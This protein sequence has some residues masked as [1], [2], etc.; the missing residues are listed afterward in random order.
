MFQSNTFRSYLQAFWGVMLTLEG[1]FYMI[2]GHN[3][4]YKY[5][6][7]VGPT[8]VHKLVCKRSSK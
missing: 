6:L 1:D 8:Y 4:L 7:V 5:V 3:K 2:F